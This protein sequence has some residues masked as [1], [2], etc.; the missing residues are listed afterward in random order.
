MEYS[1]ISYW[2]FQVIY[3]F[4]LESSISE[5]EFQINKSP[6]NGSCLINPLNGTTSTYFTINCFN[7]FDE[8]GIKD[9]SV[10]VYTTDP[11]KQMM[12]AYSIQ[13]NIEVLLPAD[14][15]NISLVNV[16]IYIRDNLDSVTQFEIN[17]VIVIP[18]WIAINTFV[19][20]L[21]Q[22]N[23]EMMNKNPIIELLASKN[24]N[25]IGQII[26]LLSQIFNLISNQQLQYVV[27]SMFIYIYQT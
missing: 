21:Q 18:D 23:I 5:I 2:K 8:D 14:S 12:I 27:T 16:I 25:I 9:Y 7:W 20:I 24:Q 1:N 17:S 6:Q 4:D 19:D 26:T 22:S 13:S 15:N 3:S 11:L 10:S